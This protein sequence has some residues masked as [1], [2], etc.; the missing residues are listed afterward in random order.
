MRDWHSGLAAAVF[1][2]S[3]ALSASDI[4]IAAEI[5]EFQRCDS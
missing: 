3:A 5:L 2:V 4:V 1:A